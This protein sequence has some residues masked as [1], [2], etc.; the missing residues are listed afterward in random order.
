MGRPEKAWA[1][2]NFAYTGEGYRKTERPKQKNKVS[3]LTEPGLRRREAW[4]A[5]GS[6]ERLG[7]AGKGLGK[8]EFR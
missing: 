3:K 4:G 7:K 8:P 1:S 6:W 2:L 5:L